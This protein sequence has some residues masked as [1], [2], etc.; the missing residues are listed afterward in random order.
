M[1]TFHFLSNLSAK[2]HPP[3]SLPSS[4]PSITPRCP[5]QPI[6]E[7]HFP[8]QSRLIS[9]LQSLHQSHFRIPSPQVGIIQKQSSFWFQAATARSLLRG[10]VHFNGPRAG[11]NFND[12]M[13][14]GDVI[15]GNLLANCVRESGDHGPWNSWD[16]VPYITNI[17]MVRDPLAPKGGDSE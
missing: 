5:L 15:E 9:P 4:P 14:G 7:P 10:N 2:Y 3:F 11:V 17:G 13:G 12:W 1:E 8:L 6:L 16:R